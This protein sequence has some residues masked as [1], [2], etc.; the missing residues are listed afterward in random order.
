MDNKWDDS[1]TK[2]SDH[3][4]PRSLSHSR[5]NFCET[6]A[7]SPAN[8]VDR[9]TYNTFAE[10]N[11]PRLDSHD[12]YHGVSVTNQILSPDTSE[13]LG[14]FSPGT[15]TEANACHNKVSTAAMATLL[16]SAPGSLM[17]DID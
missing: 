9:E 11:L 6:F 7:C 17:E 8:T 12:V 15:M 5:Q 4:I 16:V 1:Q 13:V 14:K 2:T 10:H 3:P